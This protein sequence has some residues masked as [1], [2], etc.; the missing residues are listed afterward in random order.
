LERAL[1]TR[2][3]KD[4]IQ[5]IEAK[6]LEPT[7][8]R[9]YEAGA[10]PMSRLVSY[11]YGEQ[12]GPGP[13]FTDTRRID[14]LATALSSEDGRTVLKEERN[15]DLAFD[16]AGGRRALVLKNLEKALTALQIASSDFA[17][18]ASDPEVAAM[19]QSVRSALDDLAA[20]NPSKSHDIDEDYDLT[21]ED[22]EGGD[23]LSD[24]DEDR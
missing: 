3:V 5:A 21:Q 22:E 17:D 10:E 14:H 12:D 18:F 7:S 9:A 8:D 15:L 2:G 11:L 13:L 1:N 24:G 19:A 20:G 23:E 4:F 6:D 16:A